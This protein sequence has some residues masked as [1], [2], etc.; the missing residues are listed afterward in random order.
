MGN[1]L[2]VIGGAGFGGFFFGVVVVA[3]VAVVVVI[4]AG[5]QAFAIQIVQHHP[6]HLGLDLGQSVE[7]GLHNPFLH[8]AKASHPD[9]PVHHGAEAQAIPQGSQRR[10]I[11]DDPVKG[12]S[13]QNQNLP[14]TVPCQDLG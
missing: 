3:A 14:E 12:F 13:R 2:L 10:G 6:Q 9:H 8:L 7:G 4:V 5:A 11:D 1:W